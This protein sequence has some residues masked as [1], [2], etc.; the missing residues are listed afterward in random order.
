MQAEKAEHRESGEIYLENQGSEI[1]IVPPAV[2]S[3]M[4]GQDGERERELDVCST[5]I[6]YIV[7]ATKTTTVK[8]SSKKF[9]EIATLVF[10][11]DQI[12]LSRNLVSHICM[13]TCIRT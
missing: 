7:H 8:L 5:H 13:G 6:V 3:K 9:I 1:R 12:L 10:A 11:H 2:P 4:R